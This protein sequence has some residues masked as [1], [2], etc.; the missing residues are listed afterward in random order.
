MLNFWNGHFR[1]RLAA[2]KPSPGLLIVSQDAPI[3]PVV[4]SI[5]VFWAVSEPAELQG[6]AYHLPS[7]IRHVFTR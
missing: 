1:N 3:G 5:I 2:G 6:Q 7:L 4:E